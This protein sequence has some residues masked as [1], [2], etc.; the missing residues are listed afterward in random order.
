MFQLLIDWELEKEMVTRSGI[1][2]DNGESTTEKVADMIQTASDFIFDLVPNQRIQQ[3]EFKEA[4]SGHCVI[5]ETGSKIN[6]EAGST[7][8]AEAGATVIAMKGSHVTFKR[9]SFGVVEEGA[10]YEAEHDS[11]VTVVQDIAPYLFTKTK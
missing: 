4:R 2:N 3:G 1:M 8:T 5:A 9:G 10:K 6:A 11:N 7:V